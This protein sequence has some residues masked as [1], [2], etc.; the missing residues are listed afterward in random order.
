MENI[1]KERYEYA[2]VRVE[3]LLPMVDDNT[4]A[5]D[6]NALE[7][8]IM[9]DIII[10]YEKKYYPIAKPTVADLIELSLEEKGMN[11]RQL[12]GEIGVSPSRVNDYIS[13]RAEPTLKI[14]RLLC[15][16]LNITPEA[17][18]GV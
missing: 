10:D 11:Q 9:S 13:G 18:L 16:I 4:P 17:M 2:L 6:K 15:K 8:S 1:T 5:N 7:L 14:A 12:A 3:E